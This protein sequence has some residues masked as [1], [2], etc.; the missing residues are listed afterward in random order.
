MD[1]SRPR[2]RWTVLIAALLFLTYALPAKAQCPAP[3]PAAKPAAADAQNAQAQQPA[4]PVEAVVLDAKE[5]TSVAPKLFRVGKPIVI[6]IAGRHD[7]IGGCLDGTERLPKPV[8]RPVKSAAG[9]STEVIVTIPV[10]AARPAGEFPGFHSITLELSKDAGKTLEEATVK[11]EFAVGLTRVEVIK[12]TKDEQSLRLRLVGSGFVPA[13]ADQYRVTTGTRLLSICWE[14]TKCQDT[15]AYS[16]RMFANEIIIGRIGATH[17]IT[18][19]FVVCHEDGACS[20][21]D[22]PVREPGGDRDRWFVR[23]VAAGITFLTA[24]LILYLGRQVTDKAFGSV[25]KWG[26]LFLDRETGTYSLSKLQFYTWTLVAIFSYTYLYVSRFWYQSWGDIPP[27][28][29]G[30]PGIVAIAGGAAVGSQVITNI[31]GP[32]GSGALHPALGDFITS[33]G[34]VA[35]ERVQFLIWTLIGAAGL[36]IATAQIDPRTLVELPSVPESILAI[37]GVSAFGYLGGKLAR[38]PGPVI[39]E[40]IITKGADPDAK[41]AADAAATKA[42]EVFNAEGTRIA[43]AKAKC[44]ALPASAAVQPVLDEARKAIDS[45][46]KAVTAA[47]PAAGGAI[48]RKVVEEQ[49]NAS[50]AAAKT[51][52][53]AKAALA[54]QASAVPADVAT[55]QT[56]IEAANAA[57]TSAQAV[58]GAI[59]ST[60]AAGSQTPAS[61]RIIELR[62]RTLSQDATIRI[63][64]NADPGPDDVRVSFEKLEPSPTDDRKL[65]KPRVVEKDEDAGDDMTLAKR[66]R[67]VVK[68]AAT[69][70][71]SVFAPKQ[72]R[73]LTLRNPDS[74]AVAYRFDVPE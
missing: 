23:G 15:D 13:Y 31:N 49:A 19:P 42:A 18:Q 2:H 61:F 66:L 58:L 37:S 73:T 20:A 62:G 43:A 72:K 14:G 48:N 35:A 17:D 38:N 51:A 32:K 28:P 8:R 21:L 64:K 7:V 41:V 27:I 52:E 22:P 34:V 71:E 47:K 44:A 9:E 36:V 45:A 50:A 57:A 59:P 16:G 67:I 69:D 60:A 74:Q 24:L 12:L 56:A 1:P 55:A 46:E 5:I 25:Y 3:D 39:N 40:V 10:T 4:T 70:V 30:L 68:P 63:S 54:A 6:T 11:S 33:G 53:A 29:S 65:Q 26:T